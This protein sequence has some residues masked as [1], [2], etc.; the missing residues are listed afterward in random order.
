MNAAKF[1]NQDKS[2]H[3]EACSKLIS[4]VK[5]F[6]NDKSGQGLTQCSDSENESKL[7]RR[8]R[9]LAKVSLNSKQT[10]KLCSIL[11]DSAF[12]QSVAF[13][14]RFALAHGQENEEKTG[15]DDDMR[16]S[17]CNKQ[18]MFFCNRDDRIVS[19][20]EFDGR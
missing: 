16:E 17:I 10:G 20:A 15:L 9:Q 11:K 8:Y 19:L 14:R 1:C 3:P 12:C 13:A 4:F 6:S 2:S 18:D 5:V 7:C